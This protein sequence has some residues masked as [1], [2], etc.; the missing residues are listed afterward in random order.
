MSYDDPLRL[1]VLKA[2]QESLETVTVANGYKHDLDGAVFRG[3]RTFDQ[4]FAL[5]LVCILEKPEQ[6]VNIQVPP[7]GGTT[8]ENSWDLHIQGFAPDDAVH[9]SDPAYRLAADV[10]KALVKERKRNTLILTG[11]PDHGLLGDNG[12]SYVIALDIGQP[13][14]LPDEARSNACFFYLPVTLLLS[15]DLEDP[16]S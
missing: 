11:N 9:P 10:I 6:P 15:E 16:F 14:V 8:N 2:L 7:R 12:A 4:S 13:V 5:P 1:R 3:R